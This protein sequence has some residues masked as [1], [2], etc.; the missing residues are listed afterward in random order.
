MPMATEWSRISRKRCGGI[1]K[2]PSGEMP[3]RNTTLGNHMPKA[4]EWSRISR[5]R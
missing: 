2:L 4:K 5:K 1:V 3:E